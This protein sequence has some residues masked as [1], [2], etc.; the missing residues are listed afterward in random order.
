MPEDVT[1]A[2]RSQ[3]VSA[4]ASLW[5]EGC[6]V[7]TRPEEMAAIA[8]RRWMSAERRGVNASDLEGQLRDLTKGLI[9]HFEKEPALVGP[10]RADYECVAERVARILSERGGI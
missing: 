9:A 10:L 5:E 4:I 3:V 2:V 6:P 1:D 8:I 7:A